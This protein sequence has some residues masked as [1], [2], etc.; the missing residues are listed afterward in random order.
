M[1]EFPPFRLDRVSQCLWRR[2]D[3][4]DEQRILLPPT[5]FAML[6]YL[7]EHAGRLVTQDELL[8]ALW[9]DT[10]VQP[11]VLKSHIKEIRS[12]LGDDP[13][14]ARFVET[15]PRRGYRF[16][17][18]VTDD[19]CKTNLG[20]DSPASRLVGRNREL[21]QLR[22]SLRRALHSMASANWRLSPAS[23]ASE[24]QL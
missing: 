13:K 18:S 10:F 20:V 2:G 23:R 24:R 3:D 16:I 7:V 22:G 4:A 9:A 15:L 5:A 12:A 19:S 17:A 8:D 6:G 1:K 11:E 21:E 14:N